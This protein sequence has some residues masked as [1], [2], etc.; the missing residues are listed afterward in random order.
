MKGLTKRSMNELFPGLK[1][2][3]AMFSAVQKP[4][5]TLGQA[6]VERGFFRHCGHEIDGLSC[7]RESLEDAERNDEKSGKWIGFSLKYDSANQNFRNSKKVSI[8]D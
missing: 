7:R 2:R 5:D 4:S 1:G 3:H 8:H 6:F